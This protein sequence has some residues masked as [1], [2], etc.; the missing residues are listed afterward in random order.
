MSVGGFGQMSQ[1]SQAS[2]LTPSLPISSAMAGNGGG[3]YQAH[4][5]LNSLGEFCEFY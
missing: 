3:V 1:M 5:G 2:P 4:Y